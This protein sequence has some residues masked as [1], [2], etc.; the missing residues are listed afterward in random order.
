[1]V[2]EVENRK[3][4]QVT[5][6]S[7]YKTTF[8]LGQKVDIG[9]EPN[10]FFKFYETTLEYPVTDGSTGMPYNLNAIEWLH[11]V[12][13]GMLRTVPQTLADIAWQVS[14][15]YMMLARELLMEH[16]RL[17]DFGGEPPIKATLPVCE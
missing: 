6:S 16:L 9:S 12:K 13:S 8:S 10:P 1:M 17:E 4:Y 14:Q 15:H 2:E 11:R 5:S 7:P 3:L